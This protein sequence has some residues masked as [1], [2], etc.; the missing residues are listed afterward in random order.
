M[1]F[2]RRFVLAT[3]LLAIAG[4]NAGC[5][6][7]SKAVCRTDAQHGSE[8]RGALVGV[9]SEAAANELPGV[10][11]RT[12]ITTNGVEREVRGATDGGRFDGTTI[13]V[14]LGGLA[15][16][17]R[18]PT[19]LGRT[20]LADLGGE[21]CE[22]K[23]SAG[24][25]CTPIEGDVDVAAMAEPCA[26]DACAFFDIRLHVETPEVPPASAFVQGDARLLHKEWTE[27]A[28]WQ[29]S[30]KEDCLFDNC[31]LGVEL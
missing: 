3:T 4:G 1:V 22:W 13:R 8:V 30:S 25:T 2:S 6:T 11:R 27:E 15:L 16:S 23:V 14:S 21:L 31:L 29:V 26:K 28:C 10:P 17:F 12:S 9:E 18:K 5:F 19:R 20:T 7:G 24:S